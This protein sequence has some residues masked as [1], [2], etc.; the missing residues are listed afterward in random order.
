MP[1]IDQELVVLLY[2]ICKLTNQPNL[3]IPKIIVALREAREQ[4]EKYRQ[5][6]PSE[7]PF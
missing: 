5:S 4:V 2:A 3:G 6:N 7:H 1:E